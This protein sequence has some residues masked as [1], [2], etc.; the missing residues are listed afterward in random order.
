LGPALTVITL[1]LALEEQSNALAASTAAINPNLL[2]F[3]PLYRSERFC[4]RLR[5]V[6]TK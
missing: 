3:S 5:I 6:R 4:G 2:I 1:A